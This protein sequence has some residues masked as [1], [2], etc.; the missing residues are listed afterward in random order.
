MEQI[1]SAFPALDPVKVEIGILAIALITLGNLRGL[2]EAGNIFA[3][4]TYL[5]LARA[6]LMIGLGTF[7]ILFQGDTGPT[8]TPAVVAAMQHT[9]RGRRRSSSSCGRSRPAPSR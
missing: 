9:R 1:A 3:I 6:F 4:P 8:P 5:F 2:R 7:R